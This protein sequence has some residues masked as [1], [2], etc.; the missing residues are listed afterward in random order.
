MVTWLPGVQSRWV[1]LT[2]T[3][4]CWHIGSVLIEEKRNRWKCVAESSVW[5]IWTFSLCV[6]CWNL[7][8]LWSKQKEIKRR[9]Q[10]CEFRLI[11]FGQR[12]L[13]N[14]LVDIWL[15]F[16]EQL[17]QVSPYAKA[18]E[19][20]S[21]GADLRLYPLTAHFVK[22]AKITVMT[23]KVTEKTAVLQDCRLKWAQLS[24]R[25]GLQTLPETTVCSNKYRFIYW[26]LAFIVHYIPLSLQI[27][28]RQI[29]CIYKKKRGSEGYKKRFGKTFVGVTDCNSLRDKV[30]MCLIRTLGC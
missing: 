27:F 18:R 19:P 4:L 3:W 20:V 29:W 5:V 22:W 26:L 14:P 17:L 6:S 24:L 7:T 23:A 30:C 12:D 11:F 9:Q 8:F 25:G 16:F 28:E 13:F 10:L 1:N 15:G 21:P 2:F